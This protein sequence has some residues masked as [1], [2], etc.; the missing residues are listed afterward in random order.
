V[1]LP[2]PIAEK[3]GR[4][5]FGSK[6]IPAQLRATGEERTMQASPLARAL[7]PIDVQPARPTTQ[8]Q[9]ALDRLGISLPSIRGAKK[10]TVEPEQDVTERAA[11]GKATMDALDRLVRLR[12]FEKFPTTVQTEL[13]QEAI[14]APRRELRATQQELR[15]IAALKAHKGKKP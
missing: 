15:D 14:H 1:T 11:R 12:G 10:G 4:S 6:Q 5:E 3:L 2:G 13:V 9:A 7:S 8:V